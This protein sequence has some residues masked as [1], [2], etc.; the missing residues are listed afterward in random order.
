[1]FPEKESLNALPSTSIF[2]E[3]Q[4]I[5]DTGY[6]SPIHS[7]ED[8]FQQTRLEMDRYLR[9]EPDMRLNCIKDRHIE[10][11]TVAW[12][13]FLPPA[14]MDEDVNCLSL[15]IELLKP[16]FNLYSINSRIRVLPVSHKENTLVD[17]LPIYK[18]K[19]PGSQNIQ[20]S[21]DIS[22]DHE[23]VAKRVLLTPP[24]SPESISS[25]Y[26]ELK[27]PKPIKLVKG[28]RIQ[29]N[30]VNINTTKFLDSITLNPDNSVN[31]SDLANLD[32]KKRIHRCQFNDCKKVYTK[33]SHLK[34]HQRT[35]TGEKPY[36]CTW[37]GCQW[38]FA[39]SDELTRHYRK[40]TGAKPFK[41]SSCDRCFSRSDHLAL[42][43]KRHGNGQL[44]I[45]K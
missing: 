13:E 25:P 15:D 14:C 27:S 33:S 12:N 34:A 45:S 30:R 36:K 10:V 32:L 9:S 1:M 2:Q 20:I 22:F 21:E 8:K 3:M 5:H 29:K 42:H 28:Q 44:N 40:H 19:S 6:F 16:Y 37:E 11:T 24:S 31:I 41:C 35:H 7:L 4:R 26:S 39:R 17:E 18:R 43:T 38:R 23:L